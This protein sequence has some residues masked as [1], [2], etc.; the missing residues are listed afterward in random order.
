MPDGINGG[1]VANRL[2]QEHAK[3]ERI[4]NGGY[5]ADSV[6]EDFSL[7]K[8]VN[9]LAKPFEAHKLAQTV[10]ARLDTLD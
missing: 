6:G 8:G 4:Y 7:H 2:L 9:L 1:D 5:S 10:R 3:L